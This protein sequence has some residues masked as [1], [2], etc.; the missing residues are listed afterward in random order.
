MFLTHLL[1][2]Q[3]LLRCL[4]FNNI[5]WHISAFAPKISFLKENHKSQNL[6]VLHFRVFLFRAFC[7][8]L[9]SSYHKD[10]YFFTLVQPPSLSLF[11]FFSLCL[12]VYLSLGRFVFCRCFLDGLALFVC[13]MC[14]ES[15]FTTHI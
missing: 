11:V 3:F 2:L 6:F 9:S 10:T 15:V 12:F 8:I 5:N 13:L 14:I 1:D 7:Y 4:V